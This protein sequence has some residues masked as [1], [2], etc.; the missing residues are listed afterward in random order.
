M[1]TSLVVLCL[2][3]H[4]KHDVTR[5]DTTRSTS[6]IA[7]ESIRVQYTSKTQ[8]YLIVIDFPY[9]NKCARSRSNG[10]WPLSPTNKPD[11]T[12]LNTLPP[13]FCRSLKLS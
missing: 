1:K 8:L 10:I 5:H 3:E 13:D 4:N 2:V 6:Y 12:H 7:S 11:L 9:N